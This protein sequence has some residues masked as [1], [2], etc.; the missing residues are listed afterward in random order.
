[1]NTESQIRAIEEKVT[2][3]ISTDPGSFLVEVR[4][5]PGNNVKVF[6]DADQGISIDKLSRYNRNLHKQIE[7]SGLFYDND[8]SLEVSSPGLDEPLKLHRQYMKNIGRFVEVLSKNGIR[9]EGKL[10]AATESEIVVEEEKG[11]K[12]SKEVIE[13]R[14]PYDDI[15]TTKIQIR[16]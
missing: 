1:M 3:L 2:D 13:H 12:K 7:E 4:I 9:L 11:H 8:F 6:V 15:K 16:F 5:R 14:V 10:T